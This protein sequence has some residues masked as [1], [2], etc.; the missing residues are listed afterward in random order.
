MVLSELIDVIE[1]QQE[2][3]N[4]R[5]DKEKLINT[6]SYCVNI[7]KLMIEQTLNKSYYPLIN[8]EDL[9]KITNLNVKEVCLNLL[10]PYFTDPSFIKA[11]QR[12]CQ[13]EVEEIEVEH[14]LLYLRDDSN[15]Y[16]NVLA[17]L[18]Y[19]FLNII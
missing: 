19:T 9:E 18:N 13:K 6:L 12:K 1:K 8:D 7:A 10:Y 2:L 14:C 15:I 11:E 17:Y 3:T 5:F 4:Y 16:Q